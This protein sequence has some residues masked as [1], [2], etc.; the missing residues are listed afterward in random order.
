MIAAAPGAVLTFSVKS[1]ATAFVEKDF[2]VAEAPSAGRLSICP[3]ADIALPGR[4]NVENVLAAAAVAIRCGIDPASIR[5]VAATFQGVPHR[6][7]F[8]AACDGVLYYNDSIATSPARASAGVRA[9]AKPIVLIAG[10]YDK[11]LPFAELAEALPGRVRSVVLLGKTAQDIEAA[12]RQHGPTTGVA[13]PSVCHAATFAEAVHR[14]RELAQP[15]DVVL[16]SPACA[17]YDMFPNFEA[18]GELFRT[19]VRRFCAES[20]AAAGGS[21]PARM[22]R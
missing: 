19:L 20:E 4:H 3:V 6:L 7:E 15:G 8:V 10:G 17:S 1:E 13:T 11:R 9:F 21:A 16:L 12:I 5:A 18:R 22:E 14:A 2:I